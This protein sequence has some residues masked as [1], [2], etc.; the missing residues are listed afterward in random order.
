MIKLIIFDLDGVL[1]EAKEI[2]Y[3][4]LNIA[5]EKIAGQE[6]T[7]TEQEHL[8]IYDGLKTFQKL[9]MLSEKKSLDKSLNSAI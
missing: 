6:Y 4:T 1:V 5:I 2:H 9:E 8:S 7:I 3:K